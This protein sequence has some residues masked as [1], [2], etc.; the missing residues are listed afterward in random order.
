M[1]TSRT[2]PRRRKKTL[3]YELAEQLDWQLPDAILYPP[4]AHRFIGCGKLSMKW[5]HSAGSVR[6]G[7]ACFPFKRAAARDRSRV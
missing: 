7:R 1:S 3:G 6:N 2:V 4:A 5:K